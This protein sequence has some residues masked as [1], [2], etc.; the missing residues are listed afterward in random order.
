M[1][2]RS[3]TLAVALGISVLAGASTSVRAATVTI[4]FSGQGAVPGALGPE[5]L[6]TGSIG[7]SRDGA[8]DSDSSP[9]IGSY[10]GIATSLSVTFQNIDTGETLALGL[11]AAPFASNGASVVNGYYDASNGA[12]SD[13][14]SISGPLSS[15]AFDL[16]RLQLDLISL[17]DI[18]SSDVLPSAAQ[19]NQLGSD[20]A[21]I[22]VFQSHTLFAIDL[23]D[24]YAVPEPSGVTW[25]VLVL[26]LPF[27]L[28]RLVSAA[29]R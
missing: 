12:T 22:R 27:A 10:A 13:W 7:F 28:A 1:R 24:Y 16:Q 14:F 5:T 11:A 15:N 2:R 17:S 18:L 6:V 8:V 9:S 3:L 25:F 26:L 19:L 20:T 21:R 23:F 29:R 4:Q